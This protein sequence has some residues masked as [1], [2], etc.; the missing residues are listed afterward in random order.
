MTTS[1]YPECRFLPDGRNIMLSADIEYVGRLRW[2]ARKGL[3]CD[4]A[5]IPK[6][7]WP[8]IGGPYEGRH[9]RST[10][11]H[12]DKYQRLARE[13]TCFKALVSKKRAIVDR[14]MLE[15]AI[16]DG[17]DPI[18]A[19]IIYAGVR[20]GGWWAWRGHALARAAESITR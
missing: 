16:A 18:K 2:H 14:M 5:S 3:V 4:G 20:V 19:L 9:R 1:R 7:L 6:L 8:F 13:T 10:I 11:L 12:D 17:T 15:I